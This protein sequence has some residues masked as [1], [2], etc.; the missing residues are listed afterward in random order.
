MAERHRAS[1]LH[2][3]HQS[4]GRCLA[5]EHIAPVRAVNG[6]NRPSACGPDAAEGARHSLLGRTYLYPG[7]TVTAYVDTQ[8][9]VGGDFYV[10][11]PAPGGRVL[12]AVG[13]VSGHGLTTSVAINIVGGLVGHL[14]GWF[15]RASDALDYVSKSMCDLLPSADEGVFATVL[16]GFLHASS[17]VFHAASAGHW[18]PVAVSAAGEARVLPLPNGLPCGVERSCGASAVDLKLSPGETVVLYTDGITESRSPAGAQFGTDGILQ[19]LGDAARRK[20]AISA[21]LVYDAAARY[22]GGGPACDD[23]AVVAVTLE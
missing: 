12:I 8:S 10:V 3:T 14:T 1:R 15:S 21:D 18:P 2:V 22:R 4:I 16:M 5:N 11:A 17:R 6:A 19:A 9:A 7:L 20:Q 13:D 23:S